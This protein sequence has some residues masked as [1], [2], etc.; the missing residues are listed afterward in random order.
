MKQTKD[1]N[2]MT[3]DE[4]IQVF[5]KKYYSTAI[6]ATRVDEFIALTQGNSAV[7]EYARKFDRLATFLL[8]LEVK[9]KL[10]IQ[11]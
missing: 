3:W 5:N 11:W 9:Q 8:L 1:V 10:V 2:A 7:S 4:F 6:L